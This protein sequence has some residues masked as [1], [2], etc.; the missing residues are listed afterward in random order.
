[1]LELD[2]A[3]NPVRVFLS[4]DQIGQLVHYARIT[5]EKIANDERIGQL[6]AHV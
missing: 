3:A 5:L 2:T 1:V 6:M 4:R